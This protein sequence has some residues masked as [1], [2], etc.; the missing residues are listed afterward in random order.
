VPPICGFHADWDAR[1]SA[2]ARLLREL[3]ADMVFSNVG[4]LPLAGAQRAAFR[5][6]RCVR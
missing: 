2:E 3:G 5:M 4:Y 1:V 6:P